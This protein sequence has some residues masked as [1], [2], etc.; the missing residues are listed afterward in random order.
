MPLT[1]GSLCSG[2]GGLDQAVQ[3]VLGGELAWVA[4]PDPGAAKILA[5]HHPDVP[6]LGDITVTDWSRVEPV[7]VLTAGFPC[8]DISYAGRGAGIKEGTRSGIWTH[9]VEAARVLRPRYLFVENVSGIVARRPGLDVVLADL[10]R[11]GWDA[12]WGCVRA[13]DVGAP[14]PRKR[15]FLLAWPSTE[16]P[17]VAAGSEWGVAAS[18][19]AEGWRARADAGG[20]SGAP[21]AYADR[22]TVGPVPHGEPHEPETDHPNDGVDTAGRFLGWGPY[23]PAVARWESVTGR[24]SP[25]PTEPGRNGQP[26]LSPRFAEWLMGLPVGHVTAEEIGLSRAQQFHA[27]GNGVVPQQGAAALRLLLERVTAEVAA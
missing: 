20:R 4:D 24:R 2:Y 21:A 8:Q 14:H 18:G 9:V 6:N 19:Q 17:H 27:L 10:A 16:D 7:D 12:S 15:W 23:E 13:S 11:D 25:V 3:A 22:R 5:H 26:R 1:I